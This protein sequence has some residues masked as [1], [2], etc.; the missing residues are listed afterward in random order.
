MKSSKILATIA[1]IAG[2]G[3]TTVTQ[4]ALNTANE[5]KIE[6]GSSF[7]S[8]GDN[9]NGIVEINVS[10]T[11]T[12]DKWYN[13]TD[14]VVVLPGATLTI[15]KGTVFGSQNVGGVSGTLVIANGAQIMAEGT[16]DEPII[17]TSRTDLDNWDDDASH[18]TG[19][20]PR[21]R[22]QWRE[23][24]AEWG[25]VALLGD[26]RISDTRQDPN[27]S[28]LFDVS[29]DSPIEGLPSLPNG[30]NLY[31]GLDDNDDS[32]VF[33]YVSISYGGD[34][35][36]P[37]NDSELN[38]M[39]VGGVGRATDYSHVEI[40][41]NQDDGLEIFGGTINV[42]NLAV[43]N[44]GDDSVDIDHGYR[45]KMQFILIVQGASGEFNQGSGFGDNGFEIDGTD[46]NSAGQ[47]VTATAI[48]NATTIGA[49]E[50]END[51]FL[52][53]NDSSDQLIALRDNA[54]VQ[55]WNSIFMTEGDRAL[56]NDGDDGDGSTGYGHIGT[57]T[58]EERWDTA[59]TWYHSAANVINAGGA[60]DAELIAAYTA[61]V[62]DANLLQISGSLW[63][64]ISKYGLLDDANTNFALP[65]SPAA[66]DENEG[67]DNLVA[68]S[69]PIVSVVRADDVTSNPFVIP[70]SDSGD[71][72]I[73]NITSLDP[74]AAND[75]LGSVRPLKFVAPLDGFYTPVNYRGAVG[76][77]SNWLADWTAMSAVEN[78]SAQK[79]LVGSKV[80]APIATL[81]L[82]AVASFT[83][84]DGVTYELVA[85]DADGNETV[86]GTV[87]GDGGTVNVADLLNAPVDA[88]K[89]YVVR[90][91]G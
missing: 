6:D 84:I 21:N 71:G 70:S 33:K 10:T 78:E 3:L 61:Q 47:P 19:K 45:G 44:I 68:T 24:K 66:G 67:L 14:R 58:F 11:L 30:V 48:W 13:I 54:N 87:V 52:N 91:T 37:L 40:M 65:A 50:V 82:A 36:N 18:V 16:A 81:N 89:K 69:M 79:I 32:G 8:D 59:A 90:V 28:V 76:P 15:E 5:V 73:G 62:E 1:M 12:N 7:D 64:G 63:W 17:F 20:D 42:K 57:L 72:V 56:K 29:K 55:W 83:S 77:E 85:I 88:S 75:A 38:G 49:P 80:D 22:G 27:N 41:N 43:W 46:G 26:A 2:F 4:A 34:D 9:A 51:S 23:G 35:F 39:S 60:S 25:S 74:R 53:D 86:V 31:G